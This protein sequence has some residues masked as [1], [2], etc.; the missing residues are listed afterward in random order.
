MR[1]VAG[2]G[3]H[4][5]VVGQN[6]SKEVELFDRYASTGG[7][8]VFTNQA[9]TNLIDSFA[10]LTQLATGARVA[11]LGCGS[12]V[13][14]N[15]L[16]ERGY[17]AQG[18]DIS[19]GQIE[20]ARKRYP[21]LT[22]L[23]GD[24]EALPYADGSLDGVFL[25][26]VV[27][28][29]PDASRCAAEVFRVLRPA[30]RVVAFDPNRANPFMYLYRDKSSPFYSSRGVTENERPVIAAH[31]AHVFASAGFEVSTEYLGGLS[32]QYVASP[33]MRA[34]LPVYNVLD[35]LLFRPEAMRQ[36]RSFVLTYGE[37]P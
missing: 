36:L 11:D 32:Y 20:L 12:G 19:A 4:C 31:V 7:Y 5:N 8:D 26:A 10:R 30:G 22:F 28:H 29:L 6:K 37:K 3:A 15:M 18:L 9:N 13:F 33:I 2:A 1:S 23:T 27:H 21:G 25:S 14:T 16:A 24:V 34:L 35:A 17:V